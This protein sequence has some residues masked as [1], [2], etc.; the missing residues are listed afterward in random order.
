MKKYYTFVRIFRATGPPHFLIKYVP[1]KLL[2]IEITYHTMEKG[3]TDLSEKNK[4]YWPI[5]PLHIGSYSLHKQET[6]RKRRKN[7]KELCLCL[8]GAQIS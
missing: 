7:P 6:R 2:A 5:F 1:D 3:A 4:R 8:R